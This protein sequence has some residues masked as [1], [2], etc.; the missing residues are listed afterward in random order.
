[1]HKPSLSQHSSVEIDLQASKKRSTTDDLKAAPGWPN[2]GQR[3]SA[4][5]SPPE[6]LEEW[7]RDMVEPKR[8][9]R[10]TEVLREEIAADERTIKVTREILVFSLVI[11]LISILVNFGLTWCVRLPSASP[12][13]LSLQPRTNINT[14]TYTHT[15]THT[16]TPLWNACIHCD[17]HFAHVRIRYVVDANKDTEVNKDTRQITDR[18][19]NVLR[20]DRSQ[21]KATLSSQ[22]S[23]TTFEKLEQIRVEGIEGVIG[24]RVQA[25]ARYQTGNSL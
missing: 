16:H 3:S 22:L 17:V 11:L 9:R 18:D 10:T 4:I 1:M 6:G 20:V 5:D 24:I 8:R 25:W 23:D 7:E 15:H 19:G 2:S 14:H 12:F 13:L 21:D